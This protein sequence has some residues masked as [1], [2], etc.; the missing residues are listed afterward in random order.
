MQFI[1]NSIDLLI[2]TVILNTC[3]IFNKLISLLCYACAHCCHQTHQ[4]HQTQN[5]T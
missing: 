5:I 3:M 1:Q 4:T 2:L